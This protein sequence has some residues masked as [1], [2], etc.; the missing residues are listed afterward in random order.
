MSFS[1][2]ATYNENQI[3]KRKIQD[4]PIRKPQKEQDIKRQKQS[5]HYN[6]VI[7]CHGGVV[8]TQPGIKQRHAYNIHNELTDINFL[9]SYGEIL[10]SDS[11]NQDVNTL[12]Q[13]DV[14][15]KCDFSSSAS[16]LMRLVCES[17]TSNIIKKIPSNTGEIKLS[18]MS[19]SFDTDS[20]QPHTMEWFQQLFGI[21]ICAPELNPIRI[22]PYDRFDKTASYNWQNMFNSIEQV[23]YQASSSGI[24]SNDTNF[25]Y[26]LFMFC[27]RAR[28]PD[29]TVAHIQFSPNPKISVDMRGGDDSIINETTTPSQIENVTNDIK[30]KEINELNKN[31]FVQLTEEQF[32]SFLSP[33]NPTIVE[34]INSLDNTEVKELMEEKENGKE[35]ETIGG[36]KTKRNK[37]Q[38]TKRNSK[39]RTTKRK[40]KNRKISR[41]SRKYK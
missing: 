25:T 29:S 17:K 27:C 6:I 13:C 34:V 1:Q 3:K 11:W 5:N 30:T 12:Y 21:W 8:E 22:L 31:G 41:T 28:N 38:K 24:I 23:F 18:E 19:F 20:K 33:E 26:S 2:Y 15:G 36:R 7:C 10:A 39:K 35:N 40:L 4:N 37:K 9:V 16:I 14:N 32:D